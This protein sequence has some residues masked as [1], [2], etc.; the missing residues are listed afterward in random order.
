MVCE[1]FQGSCWHRS[2]L[3]RRGALEQ[4][5]Q[6]G[7][8]VKQRHKSQRNGSMCCGI[9]SGVDGETWG[10]DSFMAGLGMNPLVFKML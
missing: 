3:G 1:A 9:F 4:A 8:L 6:R 2:I 10:T 5:W 7:D